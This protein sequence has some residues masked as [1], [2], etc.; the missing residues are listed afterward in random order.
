MNEGAPNL[1]LTS[2][3]IFRM[4]GVAVRLAR[5][6]KEAQREWRRKWRQAAPSTPTEW[7]ALAGEAL[8]GF[9][10][11]ALIIALPFV[12]LVRGSVFIYEHGRTP[13]WVAVLV[14]AFL[15]RGVGAAP[16]VCAPRRVTEPRGRCGGWGRALVIA[17]A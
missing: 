10:K 14:A 17:L 11:I 1:W 12:V 6:K 3:V 13:V 2:I 8:I 7:K 16:A 15:T 5:L 4:D 9:L